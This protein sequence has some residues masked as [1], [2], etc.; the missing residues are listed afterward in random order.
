M[1]EHKDPNDFT[2]F[3]SLTEVAPEYTPIKV[4]TVLQF[5]MLKGKTSKIM[6]DNIEVIR[7]V[8]YVV[9]APA[10]KRYYKKF[11]R[12]FP[13]DKLYF[14]KEDEEAAANLRRYVEDG[15][16]WLLLTLGQITD[17]TDMLKRLWKGN[18]S[19]E[20]KVD[21]RIWLELLAAYLD[22]EDYKDYG[23][24]LVGFKTVCNQM[25]IKIDDLWKKASEP[26]P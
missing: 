9:Y 22:L 2:Y 3:E 6:K 26:K 4:W 18:L 24:E 13:L 14:I 8:Y 1:I 16:V 12:A 19:G 25:Q 10:E 11:F 15:N 20:G 5:Y 17:T 23:K 7:Y 21:Y